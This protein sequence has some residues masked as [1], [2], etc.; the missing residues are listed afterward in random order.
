ML[1]TPYV[2]HV[3][4]RRYGR[5]YLNSWLAQIGRFQRT[6]CL[7]GR[8]YRASWSAWAGQA[9]SRW[10][11]TTSRWWCS[12]RGCTGRCGS[13][14][15]RQPQRWAQCSW[16]QLGKPDRMGWRSA[17]A[18]RA[19]SASTRTRPN[20]RFWNP[21]ILSDNI[22]GVF[23]N[24]I[25]THCYSG[26]YHKQLVVSTARLSAPSPYLLGKMFHREEC[27]HSGFLPSRRRDGAESLGIEST[28]YA[29]MVFFK[30][31]SIYGVT[32]NGTI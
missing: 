4:K 10:R 3:P 20:R 25:L 29:F 21:D 22:S 1:P 15:L 2:G 32:F 24:F 5:V 26:F 6:L 9:R 23:T 27:S 14:H 18:R 19:T 12:V 8:R 11:G 31:R 30:S 17:S 16:R 7:S 28:I 13:V